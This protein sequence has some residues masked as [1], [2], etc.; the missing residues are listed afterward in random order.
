MQPT[1][2]VILELLR[3]FRLNQIKFRLRDLAMAE[4][5]ESTQNISD[6]LTDTFH[7]IDCEH[8]HKLAMLMRV[9]QT[10]GKPLPVFNFTERQITSKYHQITGVNPSLTL[11]GSKEVLL[12][13][14]SDVDVVTSSMH[15]HGLQSWDN[16]MVDVSCLMSRKPRL[17]GLFQDN[18]QRDQEYNQLRREKSRLQ[19]EKSKYEES[20]GQTVHQMSLKLKQ[21]DK[22]IDFEVPLIPSG[23]MTPSLQDGLSLRGEIQ[24]LVML[25]GLPL[26]LGLSQLREMKERT[27]SG[28]FR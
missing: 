20:L 8:R 14:N 1:T 15:I 10:N 19:E 2:R 3:Q 16:L 12:E 24:Q 6:A 5:T 18:E 22:Q 21:I 23:I 26:F 25:P 4:G 9:S 28:S 27:N 17:I 7:D 13:F 11:M